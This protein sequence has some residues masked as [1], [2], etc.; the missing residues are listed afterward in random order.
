[1]QLEQV[2]GITKEMSKMMKTAVNGAN[3]NEPTDIRQQ[4]EELK[5]H[6]ARRKSAFTKA[7]RAMLVLLDED[8]PS[9]RLPRRSNEC[10]GSI[11]G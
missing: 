4:V 10:H 7:K 2:A 8:L 5:R 11:D 6:K 3:N 9:R 1:M